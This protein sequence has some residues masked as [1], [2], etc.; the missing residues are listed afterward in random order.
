MD[1]WAPARDFVS[2]PTFA[3]DR[4]RAIAGLRTAEID[5]PISPVVT[6]LMGLP[7]C[8]TLQSCYGHFCLGPRQ[9]PHN[10]E[11]LPRYD[12]GPVLYRIAYVAL[13]LENSPGGNRLRA[14]LEAVAAAEPDV[15]QFGSPDWF[16]EQQVNSYSL[17]VQPLHLA[18][19]DSALVSHAE[20]LAIEAAR[21]R[22][23]ERLSRALA[24]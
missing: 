22:F 20:A 16:W 5:E 3:T 14:A 8:F 21:D 12:D 9:D 18:D 7:Y 6:A 2:H 13:C 4:N 17:Q 24:W 10:L 23:F 15:V 1:T 11:R 19:R